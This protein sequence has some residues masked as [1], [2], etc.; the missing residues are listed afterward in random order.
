MKENILSLAEKIR[1]LKPKV[2]SEEA[3]KQ[4]MVL[5]L[6]QILGYDIFNP[7]EVIPEVPCDISGK[8][9]KVDYAI[10]LNDEHMILIECKECHQNIYSH[11]NQMKKYFVA[12]DARIAVLTNGIDYL[13]FTDHDKAHIM[14]EKP[15]YSINIL[16]LSDE[17]I[18]FLSDF[19]KSHFNPDR[20]L[21]NA[22]DVIVR[23]AIM[24]RI[25]EEINLPSREMISILY[26]GTL[27][28]VLTDVSF[29]RYSNIVRDC[30]RQ[31]LKA[32]F[33]K[34]DEV[35]NKEDESPEKLP[36]FTEDQEILI[37]I[38]KDWLSEFET[39]KYKIVFRKL[40]N[41]Y[42]SVDYA[43]R[44]WPVCRFKVR[45]KFDDKICVKICNNASVANCTEIYIDNIQN[46]G[47]ARDK[48]LA[49]CADSKDRLIKYRSN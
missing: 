27:D 24:T 8:G 12:S 7:E 23:T 39:N 1:T 42:I 10:S 46:F 16:D 20:V 38:I 48:I 2:K 30:F 22:N 41:G 9:D 26:S 34:D 4:S 5:P 3:T 11:V 6:L 44:W 36:I 15:Y 13:F 14:D 28:S 17:D 32:E 49:Q 18:T 43:N 33:I 45:P 35:I 21:S 40:S 37:K 29:A 31:L 19:S 47:K 25:K